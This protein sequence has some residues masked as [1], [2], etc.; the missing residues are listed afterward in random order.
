MPCP[1]G[2]FSP[3]NVASCHVAHPCPSGQED[4][5]FQVLGQHGSCVDC[6]AGQFKP[7]RWESV[8]DINFRYHKWQTH[9]KVPRCSPCPAGKF[10]H[11][12]AADSC[13]KCKGGSY[14][15]S[16]GATS[17]A[18]CP[19]GQH[20]T[21]THGHARCTKLHA[22][23]K[24]GGTGLTP[25]TPSAVVDETTDP[26]LTGNTKT[27]YNW[28]TQKNTSKSIDAVQGVDLGGW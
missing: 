22:K 10:Q 13:Q 18:S 28:T 19:V 23:R 2:K 25:V 21:G 27:G 1:D 8:S 24:A 15:S 12:T 16:A 3:G 9:I 5:Y 11:A 17:C 26:L 7:E 14:Q 6:A 20:T 4:N